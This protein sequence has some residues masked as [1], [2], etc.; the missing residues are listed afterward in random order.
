MRFVVNDGYLYVYADVDQLAEGVRVED[1]GRREVQVLA[2]PIEYGTNNEHIVEPM[3]QGIAS[4]L[5][6]GWQTKSAKVRDVIAVTEHPGGAYSWLSTLRTGACEGSNILDATL[7]M[8]VH[9]IMNHEDQERHLG[10]REYQAISPEDGFVLEVCQT[11][12]EQ[13]SVPPLFADSDLLEEDEPYDD[14]YDERPTWQD[15]EKRYQLTTEQLMHR[16]ALGEEVAATRSEWEERADW[17]WSYDEYLRE[18]WRRTVVD[19]M[20][21]EL[22]KL[23]KRLENL[24]VE[25]QRISDAIARLEEQGARFAEE[26]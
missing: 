26:N 19:H 6:A 14:D 5:E 24:D 23:R 20:T 8:G 13:V 2:V 10:A 3:A 4:V 9:F 15:Y 17:L 22:A 18:Q 1:D 11:M 12:L 16:L 21:A 7:D 25:R